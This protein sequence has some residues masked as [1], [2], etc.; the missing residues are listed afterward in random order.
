MTAKTDFRA[1]ATYE[2][3]VLDHRTG[4]KCARC[5][6]VLHDSIINFGEDLP[7]EPL[8]RAF[9]NAKRADLCLVLGSSLTVT[10]ANDVPAAVCRRKRNAQ[11]VICN[12]QE[13]PLD[14]L[15]EPRIHSN[16][17]DL[18]TR[19]MDKLGIPIPAF[20]LHRRLFVELVSTSSELH[21][22]I[23]YG[24]DVDG[25]P[26]TFLRSVKLANNR[27]V[28]QSEPF[29]LV[30]RERVDDGTEFALELEFMGRYGEPNLE[31]VHRVV[32]DDERKT[33]YLLDYSPG[34]GVWQVSKNDGMDGSEP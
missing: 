4:R 34:T 17:D 16:A 25:T 29:E 15:S 32:E 24:V 14:Y 30:F 13:T 5:G 1:V 31:I 7:A 23:V 19:V 10:P 3:T 2:I 12:L 9:D 22:L 21:K 27:R 8:R 33:L 20:V 28:A 6:G 26:A 11:L 18:M